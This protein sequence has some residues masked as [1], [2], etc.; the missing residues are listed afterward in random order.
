M[1]PRATARSGALCG[2]ICGFLVVVILWFIEVST[3]PLVAPESEVVTAMGAPVN[4]SLRNR[5]ESESDPLTR[6]ERTRMKF[7]DTFEEKWK[8]ALG[9]PS[10]NVGFWINR[11]VDVFILDTYLKELEGS[12]MMERTHS[13]RFMIAITFTPKL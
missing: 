4:A 5:T 2:L 13:S 11:D 8:D 12:W 10:F 3:Q 7:R 1:K 6:S 9:L